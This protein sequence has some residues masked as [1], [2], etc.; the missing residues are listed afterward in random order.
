MSAAPLLDVQDVSKV[1][2]GGGLLG[3]RAGI[4]AVDKVSFAMAHGET[5]ALVGESG[6]GKTTT[7]RMVVRLLDPTSGR[8]IF[9]GVDLA[10]LGAAELREA[11]RHFQIVFQDPFASLS[12]RERILD[13]VGEPLQAH[14]VCRTRAE[15]KDRVVE[16]LEQVGLNA[17]HIDRFPHQF[18]GGQR[19]R[20]GIARG[21]A[22]NPKLVV[23]D[24]PVSALDVSVQSQVINLLQ[25][26]QAKL[27]I[28]YLIVAHD[29]A[30]VRHI[31]RRVA[32]MYLG[33]IVELADKDS[34]FARPHHP[35]TQALISA[36]PVPDP[37]RRN[38]RIVLTGDVPSPARV[39][40]GCRF[41]PRCP[42]AQDICRKVDPALN[43]AAPGHAVACHFAKPS[44]IPVD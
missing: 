22:L 20:I 11:R 37:Q 40:S 23:A 27:G 36:A 41:H 6:C 35:Y 7:A 26:L 33:R 21:I 16:L 25:D 30:V 38:K 19:Q 14:G 43:V 34:L 31:A 29:L 5:L 2:G 12:P 1:Y 39:P 17:G 13:I 15:L 4:H 24:E 28:A 32:V 8:I 3:G 10:S 44:P 9:D 18:S 42:I